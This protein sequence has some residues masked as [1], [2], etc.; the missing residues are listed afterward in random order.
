VF[1]AK[2]HYELVA[3]FRYDFATLAVSEEMRRTY[4]AIRLKLGRARI[5]FLKMR[6]F[7]EAIF[8]QTGLV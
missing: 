8:V 2:N 6:E 3:N 5:S 7:F 4:V 1:L